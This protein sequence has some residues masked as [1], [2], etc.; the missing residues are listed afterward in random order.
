MRCRDCTF[1]HLHHRPPPLS[2]PPLLVPS[3]ATAST[4]T[5][6][7]E[8]RTF[9]VA[10]ASVPPLDRFCFVFFNQEIVGEGGDGYLCQ[11]FYGFFL[12]S[13]RQQPGITRRHRKKRGGNESRLLLMLLL[14]MLDGCRL[15]ASRLEMGWLG[16][17]SFSF[18][19]DFFSILIPPPPPQP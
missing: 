11:F 18:S 16:G 9:G 13:V 14:L 12:W 4:A 1:H 10:S 6:E 15:P 17:S 19:L 5:N 8:R 3:F 7:T 2:L